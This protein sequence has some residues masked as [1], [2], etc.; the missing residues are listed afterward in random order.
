MSLADLTKDDPLKGVRVQNDIIKQ[1]FSDSRCISAQA[2]EEEHDVERID[3][4]MA[5]S[6]NEPASS[7]ATR[8]VCATGCS[9]CVASLETVL[10]QSPSCTGM[11]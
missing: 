4:S 3:D 5:A 9:T 10:L 11:F 1:A 6:S 8:H 2:S 7:G